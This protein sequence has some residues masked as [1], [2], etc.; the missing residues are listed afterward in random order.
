MTRAARVVLWVYFCPHSRGSV[1][2]P[3]QGPQVSICTHPALSS[4]SSHVLA[5]LLGHQAL[6][7]SRVF[8]LSM[9]LLSFRLV[10]S[11]HL[12]LSSRVISE[13]LPIHVCITLFYYF[14]L[15]A[16]SAACRH[17]WARDPTCTTAVTQATAETRLAL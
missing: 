3:R 12:G 10:P 11:H 2:S 5:G 14:S 8:A 17:S 15:L 16:V 1:L 6:S 4:P 13:A 9:P 7:C